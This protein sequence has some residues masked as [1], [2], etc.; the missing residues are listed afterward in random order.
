VSQTR[1]EILFTN[2]CNFIA[3]IFRATSVFES[4]YSP[5]VQISEL[6]FLNG[7]G[8]L[9]Q[10]A[11]SANRKLSTCTEKTVKQLIS[12]LSNSSC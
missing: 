8:L 3:L 9:I 1:R 6:P 7:S 10:N 4:S 2:G 11:E 5:V 12:C